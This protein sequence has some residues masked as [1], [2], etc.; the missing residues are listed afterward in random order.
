MAGEKLG[1]DELEAWF[2]ER[3]IWWSQRAFDSSGLA[4][5]G[6]ANTP[7]TCQQLSL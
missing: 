5:L 6:H 4:G 1:C 2:E 7:P 3:S